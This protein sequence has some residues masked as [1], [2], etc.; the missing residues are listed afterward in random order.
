MRVLGLSALRIMR[1]CMYRSVM[2]SK[3]E[4]AT[5]NAALPSANRKFILFTSFVQY[6]TAEKTADF[7]QRKDIRFK[8]HSKHFLNL[9]YST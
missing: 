9:S 1:F 2:L 5:D 6:S 8:T 3:I 4:Q 7:V